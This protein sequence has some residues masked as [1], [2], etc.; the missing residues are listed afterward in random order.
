[1]D[2]DCYGAEAHKPLL[3]L[4]HSIRFQY[5]GYTLSYVDRKEQQ[6]DSPTCPPQKEI[7]VSN[8]R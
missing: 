4:S 3:G 6:T 1:M 5:R 2:T 7:N 8:Y